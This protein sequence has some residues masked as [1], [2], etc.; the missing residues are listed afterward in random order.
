MNAADA[1]AAAAAAP[2]APGLT[3]QHMQ[4]A[5]AHHDRIRKSTDLPLFYGEKDKDTVDARTFKDRFEAA[6]NIANWNANEAR[7]IEQFYMILRGKALIWWRSLEDI[8]DFPRDD[9]G[10]YNNWERVKAEFLDAYAVRN[11]AKAACTNLQDL[12]QRSTEN[13]QDIY[14]RVTDAYHRMK[15][16]IPDAMFQV[17]YNVNPAVPADIKREGIDDMGRFFTQQL[18]LASLKEDIRIKTMEAGHDT[19]QESL[20]TARD[21]EA[22]LND[23]ARRSQLAAIQQ[24]HEDDGMEEFMSNYWSNRD[25]SELESWEEQ[26]LDK[27]NAIRINKGKRPFRAGNKRFGGGGANRSQFECRYCKIKGHMQ[28]ECRKRIRDGKPQVDMHGK[29]FTYENRAHPIRDEGE[30]EAGDED[31]NVSALSYYGINSIRK[32]YLN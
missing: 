3:Q 30:D 19:I 28:K 27:I 5:M 29:P 23:K 9:Q 20:R 31:S 2:A 10:R 14:L 17:R 26:A 18:F 7:K 22:I 6:C 11:T 25:Y 8:P 21:T 32:K 4:D 1:A 15:E 24:E 12:Y 13:V 16:S